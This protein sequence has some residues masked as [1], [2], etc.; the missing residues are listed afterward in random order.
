[1]DRPLFVTEPEAGPRGILPRYVRHYVARDHLLGDLEGFGEVPAL[2]LREIEL[3]E[4][5]HPRRVVEPAVVG[6]P[7]L[8]VLRAGARRT[9]QRRF[10]EK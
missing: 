6:Q 5:H 9:G 10:P 1:L 4:Q 8:G 7:P 3:P 2:H